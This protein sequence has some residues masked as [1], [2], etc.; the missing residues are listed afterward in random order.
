MHSFFLG[1][2]VSACC[3]CPALV[4]SVGWRRSSSRRWA[5]L[6]RM[7]GRGVVS[8][9]PDTV[10]KAGLTVR[11]GSTD[12]ETLQKVRF[13]EGGRYIEKVDRILITI[14]IDLDDLDDGAP[15]G[16]QPAEENHAAAG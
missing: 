6:R 15:P 9:S 8:L 2:T 12:L 14:R 5:G 1:D 11:N 4:K 10:R 16:T 3:P 7:P 13:T